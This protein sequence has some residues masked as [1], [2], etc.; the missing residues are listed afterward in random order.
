MGQEQKEK[1]TVKSQIEL[2]IKIKWSS[3]QNEHAGHKLL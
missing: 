1:W 3:G 2:K